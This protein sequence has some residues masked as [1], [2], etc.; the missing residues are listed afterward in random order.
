ME[1]AR[2]LLQRG[3]RFNSESQKL[4]I[5]VGTS[6]KRGH[7]RQQLVALVPFIAKTVVSQRIRIVKS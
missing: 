2:S 6:H 3:L 4:W 1:N 5:E 7:D